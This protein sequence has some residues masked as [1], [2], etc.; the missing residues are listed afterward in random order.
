[1]VSLVLQGEAGDCWGGGT[2]GDGALA[3]G[4]GAGGLLTPGALSERL[5]Y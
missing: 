2:A 3:G 4:L 5:G 1:M